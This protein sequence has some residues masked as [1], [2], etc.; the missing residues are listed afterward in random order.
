MQQKQLQQ[1]QQSEV[2]ARKQALRSCKSR[3]T[4]S[5]SNAVLTRRKVA[6]YG[7]AAEKAAA[8]MAVAAVAAALESMRPFALKHIKG[9]D[10]TGSNEFLQIEVD[11]G[12]DDGAAHPVPLYDL[13]QPQSAPQ[14]SVLLLDEKRSEASSRNRGVLGTMYS[15]TYI[16]TP[17]YGTT[18]LKKS[19][20]YCACESHW[21]A[22]RPSRVSGNTGARAT[23]FPTKIRSLPFI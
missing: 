7:E 2:P 11:C 4:I 13:S 5:T 19:M 12:K 23:R 17:V 20:K 10:E 21:D 16:E 14:T 1:Q 3:I 22:W 18:A 8:D 6:S 9:T 15:G